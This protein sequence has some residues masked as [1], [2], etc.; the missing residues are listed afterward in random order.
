[1]QTADDVELSV[2]GVQFDLVPSG[3][4]PRKRSPYEIP[5]CPDRWGRWASRIFSPFCPFAP[6]L[7]LLAIL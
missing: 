7:M 5:V 4:I 6:M 1:M 2:A 3:K